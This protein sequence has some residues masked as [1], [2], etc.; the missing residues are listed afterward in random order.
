MDSQFL[1][2]SLMDSGTEMMDLPMNGGEDMWQPKDSQF[3]ER[4]NAAPGQSGQ[5]K[6]NWD[7]RKM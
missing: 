7:V 1:T 4:E 3:Q 6:H 5:D 2:S